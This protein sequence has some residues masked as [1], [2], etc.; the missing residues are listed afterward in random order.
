MTQPPPHCFAW[1][2]RN[3]A[4]LLLPTPTGTMNTFWSHD[5][6]GCNTHEIEALLDILDARD[7]YLESGTLLSLSQSYRRALHDCA[8][9]WGEDDDEE[10]EEEGL[11]IDL[12]RVTAA[13]LH[14]SE[15]F[16]LGPES[17]HS[18][19]FLPGAVTAAT[20][21]CLRFHMLGAISDTKEDDE[22]KALEE[23]LQP[24]QLD[25][26]KLYWDVIERNI[27]R[28]YLDQAWEWISRHSLFYRC[29]HA[30]LVM[31]DDYQQAMLEEDRNGFEALRALLRCAPLPGGRSNQFDDCFQWEEETH[32]IEEEEEEPVEGILTTSYKLWESTAR[33]GGDMPLTYQPHAANQVYLKWKQSVP[34]LAPINKLKRRIPQLQRVLDMLQ[35]NLD[36]ISFDSWP[37][38]LCAQLLYKVP[39]LRIGDIPVRAARIMPNYPSRDKYN[40]MVLNIMKGNVGEVI[41]ALIL[42]GGGSGAALPA[43]MVGF[44]FV[45]KFPGLDVVSCARSSLFL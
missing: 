3:P 2:P 18:Q 4:S 19:A 7:A 35:G 20:V 40:E 15:T 29:R 44:L 42:L 27:A 37:E 38:E 30:P 8:S 36:D 23:S 34:N 25:G 5:G 45:D 1:D 6:V 16:L 10:E 31:D 24:D 21:R 22:L 28:G 41:K 26:G 11:S 17:P 12:L 14:L 33:A 9:S 43:V 13:A 32:E 39:S